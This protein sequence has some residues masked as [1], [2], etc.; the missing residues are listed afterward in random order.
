M[1]AAERGDE[2]PIACLCP[3]QRYVEKPADPE[4]TIADMSQIMKRF[5]MDCVLKLSEKAPASGCARVRKATFT[6]AIT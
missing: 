6:L 5:E 3:E 1:I 4:K 2:T